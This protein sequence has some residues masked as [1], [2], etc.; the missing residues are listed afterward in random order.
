[1]KFEDLKI[2]MKVKVVS[3]NGFDSEYVG[4]TGFISQLD[5]CNGYDVLVTFGTEIGDN[6]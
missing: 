5:K 6:D 4:K 1:M 3:N 2:G